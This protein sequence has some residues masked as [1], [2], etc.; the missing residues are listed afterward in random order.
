MPDLGK[1]EMLPDEFAPVPDGWYEVEVEKIDTRTSNAGNEYLALQLSVTE[2]DHASRKFFVNFNLWHPDATVV[3]IA[4]RS[5]GNLFKAAGFGAMGETD[6][7]GGQQVRARVVSKPRKDDPETI[8]NVVRDFRSNG[9]A[10]PPSKGT[11][12]KQ[13]APWTNAA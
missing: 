4:Q 8:D 6:Q 2:G 11:P 3:K 9:A 10:R 7:L 12:A 1:F 5:M 13:D